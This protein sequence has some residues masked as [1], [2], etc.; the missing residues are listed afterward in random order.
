MNDINPEIAANVEESMKMLGANIQ[1]AR[2]KAF[3]ESRQDFAKRLGCSPVTLDCLERGEPG[4]AGQ[5]Y[6]AA[7]QLMHVLHAVV[8]VASPELLI[9]TQIP[10]EFPA[11]FL[12]GVEQ[13]GPDA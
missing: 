12:S 4:V 2:K 11:N 13:E 3:R 9:A 1:S 10:P 8:D 5:W 6:F 7:F